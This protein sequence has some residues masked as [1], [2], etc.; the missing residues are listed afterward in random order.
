MQSQIVVRRLL[1]ASGYLI[2][3]TS[4]LYLGG[5]AV[6]QFEKISVVQWGAS[7]LLWVG[8]ASLLS[9]LL[10]LVLALSW[11]LMSAPVNANRDDVMRLVSVYATTSVLKY[12][13]GNLFHFVGRNVVGKDEE[14]THQGL[15]SATVLEVMFSACSAML[16]GGAF[17]S[18]AQVEPQWL[19]ALVAVVGVGCFAVTLAVPRWRPLVT[20]L[21]PKSMQDGALPRRI[22]LPS[23]LNFSAYCIMA[24]MVALLSLS[25]LP[26]KA[27]WQLVVG[28]F[29]LGWLVGFAVPGAPGGVG[30][31]ESVL[32]LAL[33]PT[34]GEADALLLALVTRLVSVSGDLLLLL[35]GVTLL[36]PR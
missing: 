7:N 13:P 23:M 12:L 32:V 2:L 24:L 9:L 15:A 6:T 5:I 26:E 20:P 14:T 36:R 21:M 19:Y 33:A 27:D 31:R 35:V 3:A 25:L 34:V 18:L 29:A 28:V 4:L 11:A 30:V 22:A 1:R 17:V 16:V 10:L 8:A